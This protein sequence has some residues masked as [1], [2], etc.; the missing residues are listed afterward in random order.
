MNFD[1]QDT[2]N[3]VVDIVASTLAVEKGTIRPE[4]R[5]EQ[6]GADSLD[7]LEII[8]KL[9]EGF[10]VEIDDQKAAQMATVQDTVDYVQTIRT[11]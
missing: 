7:V 11:R 10:G 8:M 5:F 3:K 4:S 1:K 2:Y 6:L 9:E